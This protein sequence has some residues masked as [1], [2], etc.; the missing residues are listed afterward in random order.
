MKKIIFILILIICLFPEQVLAGEM[1]WDAQEFLNRPATGDVID[2]EVKKPSEG[3]EQRPAQDLAAKK[4]K[5]LARRKTTETKSE[6]TGCRAGRILIE[7]GTV[8]GVDD[9]GIMSVCEVLPSARSLDDA[10]DEPIPADQTTAVKTT[11]AAPLPAVKQAPAATLPAVKTTPSV[12]LPAVKTAPSV[13]LSAVKTTP[14]APLPPAL[15]APPDAATLAQDYIDFSWKSTPG[16]ASYRLQVSRD[17][18]FTSTIIDAV[19][20]LTSHVTVTALESSTY[21]WRVQA[22]NTLKRNSR[23][24]PVWSVTVD[25]ARPFNTTSAEFIDDGIVS[26]NS[27]AV[28]LTISAANESGVAAYAVSENRSRPTRDETGWIE[29]PATT[30]Y[31]AIVPYTL[32]SG[33]GTK[34]VSVWFKDAAG[35]MSEAARDSITLDTTPPYTAITNQPENPTS[36]TTADFSFASTEA[37]STFR[38]SLDDGAYAVCAGPR[39]FTGLADGW[40]TVDVKATDAAGNTDPTPARYTWMVD[41]TPPD[42]TFTGRP[43]NPTNSTSAVF[44]FSS[45]E[46]GSTFQCSLDNGPYAVCTGPR[47]YAGLA[48]GSHTFAIKTTDAAGNTD[49]TPARYAWTIDT[50]P[51]DTAI[52]DQPATQTNSTSVDFSFASTEEG[53][54]FQCSLDNGVYAACTHPRSYTGLTAGLHTFAVKATD[55]VGNVDKTPTRYTWT[56]D[57]SP[58]DTFI[59]SYPATPTNSATANFGFSSTEAGSIFQCSLDGRAYTACGG[60]QS[61][62]RLAEGAH[63]LAVK[64]MDAAGNAD[65]VPARHTW[66]VDTTPPDT[67]L[68]IQPADLTNSTSAN[69]SF[70]STE[71]ESI[72]E[73][74]LDDGDL[75]E[76]SSPQSYAYL[77][78]GPHTLMVRATDIAGNAD[79]KPVRYTWSIDTTPPDTEITDQPE[80]STPSASAEFN[81]SSTEAGSTFQCSLDSGAYAPCTDPQS[82][83]G[84]AT[85]RH[86]FSVRATDAVGNPDPTAAIFTWVATLPPVNLTKP[87]F[88]NKGGAYL[89]HGNVVKLSISA[90]ETGGKGV[91]A[92]FISESPDTPAA[93]DPGWVTFS[94]RKEFSHIVNYTLSEGSGRKTVY[95]WFR[96]ADGNVSDVKS[97]TIYFFNSEP[98]LMVFLLLQLAMI[99]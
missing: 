2:E 90:A 22:T 44:S 81:F 1:D 61:Y 77:A 92:Y 60:L 17:S 80:D 57:I 9:S 11:P 53:S 68:T 95:V 31:S 48:E 93:S 63:T 7:G 56:I 35:H 49:P 15:A 6:P 19:T 20:A 3:D 82:Y 86:T 78:D 47:S 84:L 87:S 23:W 64:A 26:T 67:A 13:T 45:T 4:K 74:R 89:T 21:F 54:T 46:A 96:D 25:Y 66:T 88:I 39:A 73:C 33:D 58:P 59:T 12:T 5:P 8:R 37:G 97:D 38:C 30:S 10:L 72:F 40:H 28:W 51:P 36:S 14:G 43:A 42:A 52:T 94:N 24:S 65:P 75:E 55:A 29:V 76:C 18:D 27:T 71:A 98:L 79:P 41:T 34:T 50:T 69:F 83:A 32:S 70:S 62:T 91:K 99:F 16:A 85:G